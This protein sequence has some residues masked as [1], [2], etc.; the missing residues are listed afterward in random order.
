MRHD[1]HVRDI[2]GSICFSY[3]EAKYNFTSSYH[4]LMHYSPWELRNFDKFKQFVAQMKSG[5]LIGMHT[6][7]VGRYFIAKCNGQYSTEYNRDVIACLGEQARK[8]LTLF[9]DYIAGL[10]ESEFEDI[11]ETVAQTSTNICRVAEIS[12]TVAR[13]VLGVQYERITALLKDDLRD[14]AEAFGEPAG[15]SF[16]GGALRAQ[17]ARACDPTNEREELACDLAR[18]FLYGGFPLQTGGAPKTA[19]KDRCENQRGY[20]TDGGQ[21][22][23]F[24][25]D[26]MEAIEK[27][28][29]VDVLAHPNVWMSHDNVWSN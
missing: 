29:D 8:Y 27:G 18:T 3:L 14:F 17:V 9:S 19:D 23:R 26:L 5:H 11:K 25:T 13:D 2:P 10:E 4:I 28:Q 15:T 22:S 20:V 21:L 7:P 24:Q 1:V 16:H 6:E 12:N